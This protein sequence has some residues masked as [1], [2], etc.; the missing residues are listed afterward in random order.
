[1]RYLSLMLFIALKVGLR[2]VAFDSFTAGD[3]HSEKPGSWILLP[4][5]VNKGSSHQHVYLLK[6]SLIR[7]CFSHILTK[8]NH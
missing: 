8:T 3:L 4:K 7:S 6:M 5:Y 1:M 2:C